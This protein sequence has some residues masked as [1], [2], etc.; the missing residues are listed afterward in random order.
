MTAEEQKE[1]RI[2]LAADE[3]TR[4]RCL[5]LTRG[6]GS[7]LYGVKVHILVDKHGP[8]IIETVKI[9]GARR[10]WMDAKL[11][12]IPNTVG[13]RAKEYKDVGVDILTVMASGGI[14]MMMAAVEKG[15]SRI[16]AVTILTSLSEEETSLI[17]GMPPKAAVLNLARMAKLAGVHGVVCSPQEVEMLAKRPEL[18][19]LEFVVPGIR[20][21]GKDAGDQKR[22]GTPG[23]TIKAG[24]HRLVIGRQLTDAKDPVAELDAIEGEIA[25]A[26]AA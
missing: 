9:S 11:C 25:A 10:V 6:L 14:E 8:N 16:Y 4:E 21:A 12:D 20:S 1:G 17:Y 26:L 13:R 24:A 5:E 18:K 2:V 7:Q 23:A 19:G 3:L 15:P 22:I